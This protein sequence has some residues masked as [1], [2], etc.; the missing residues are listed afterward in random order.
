MKNRRMKDYGKAEKNGGNGSL[1]EECKFLAYAAVGGILVVSE[2][3][4]ALD[5]CSG[6]QGKAIKLMLQDEARFGCTSDVHRC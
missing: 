6:T 1:T 3:K 5:Q 4:A 2:I